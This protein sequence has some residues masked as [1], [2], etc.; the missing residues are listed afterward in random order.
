MT[1]TDRSDNIR[2]VIRSNALASEREA[3]QPWDRE[4]EFEVTA[5]VMGQSKGELTVRVAGMDK[6]SYLTICG[7]LPGRVNGQLWRLECVRE[8]GRIELIDGEPV[9]G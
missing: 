5:I 7:F 6:P 1:A 4:G 3:L 9:Q 8:S 2:S